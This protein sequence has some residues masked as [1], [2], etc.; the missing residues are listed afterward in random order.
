MIFGVT[1]IGGT[2]IGAAFLFGIWVAAQ[3]VTVKAM[4]SEK[5]I[6]AD[7]PMGIGRI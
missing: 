6:A 4:I 5:I 2:F 1:I 7:D 3:G